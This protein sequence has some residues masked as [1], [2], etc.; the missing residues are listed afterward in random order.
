MA[1]F[2]VK[3]SDKPPD[4]LH[5]YGHG[6]IENFSG[7]IESIFII[8]IALWIGYE[9]VEKL[10]NGFKPNFLLYGIICMVISLISNI[11]ISRYLHKIAN[12]TFSAALKAAA[13]HND[14]DV[15]ASG[16]VLG[17][18]LIIYFTGWIWIDPIIAF[19]IAGIILKEG[20]HLTKVNISNLI[21][22]NIIEDEPIIRDIIER[23]KDIISLHKLRTRRAGNIKIIDVHVMLDYNIKL[24][25]AHTIC[26]CIE[27]QIYENLGS[28]DITIHP[29]PCY[30]R[31]GC[32]VQK[33]ENNCASC[34]SGDTKHHV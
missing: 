29:E 19:I 6:K 27:K 32:C 31:T 23:N 9:S 2:A 18:L 4:R 26:D 3:S 28:C 7:A 14:A 20:F 16:G 22:V 1:F 24:G 13:L 17:G 34:S 21:D 15:W 12:N 33:D 25:E 30:I 11:F 10:L 8:L 5:G